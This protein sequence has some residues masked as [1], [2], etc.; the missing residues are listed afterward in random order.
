MKNKLKLML[1]GLACSLTAG[2]QDVAKEKAFIKDNM[3]FAAQ[4][5]ALM[6]KTPAQGKDG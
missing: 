6:M 1:L 5:Y 2:A 4:Q 3:T